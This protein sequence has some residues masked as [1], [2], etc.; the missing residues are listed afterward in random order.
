MRVKNR[1]YNS[2]AQGLYLAKMSNLS[3]HHG[4]GSKAAALA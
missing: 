4:A 3:D 1:F 2:L